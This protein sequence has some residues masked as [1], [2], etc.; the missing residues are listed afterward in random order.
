MPAP[1]ALDLTVDQ[2]AELHQLRDH[3]PT[4]YVRERAAAILKVGA[5]QSVRAVARA[6]LLRPRRRETVAAWVRRYRAEG[7]AGLRVR[8]GRG[9]K[10]A[11]SPSARGAGPNRAG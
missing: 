10:P 11:F 7:V 4:P 3:D 1:L 9:R 5:G 8:P 2:T 6:G